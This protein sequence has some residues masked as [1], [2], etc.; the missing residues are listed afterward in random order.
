MAPETPD[1][2]RAFR[3]AT[4]ARA[5]AKACLRQVDR[6]SDAYRRTH[7]GRDVD[8]TLPAD[9]TARDEMLTEG[10]LLV[11]ATD[12]LRSRLERGVHADLL[13]QFT[14][15]QAIQLGPVDRDP[16]DGATYVQHLRNAHAHDDDR[17]YF[18]DTYGLSSNLVIGTNWD[19]GQV[20]FGGLD[21]GAAR[22]SVE[23]ILVE[24]E[25]RHARARSELGDQQA[26]TEP[27]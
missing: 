19:P 7:A 1:P 16:Y 2:V 12:R 11:M 13:D 18:V 6:F 8:P 10:Y 21:V 24:L 22:R 26:N 4:D 14:E 25:R 27:A 3:D 15:P 20:V 23:A 9:G 5:W 17:R